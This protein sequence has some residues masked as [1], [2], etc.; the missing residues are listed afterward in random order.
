MV[1][2]ETNGDEAGYAAMIGHLAGAESIR[3][4]TIPTPKGRRYWFR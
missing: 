3:F 4:A 1:Y 2:Q